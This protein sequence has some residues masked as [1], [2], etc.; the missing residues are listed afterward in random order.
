[1]VYDHLIGH[2]DIK[3]ALSILKMRG[4]IPQ[5]LLFKGKEGVGKHLFARSF[6]QSLAAS[7]DIHEYK[8]EGKAFFHPIDQIKQI[9]KESYLPPVQSAKKIFIIDQADRMLPV[10][11]NALLKTLEEPSENIV[12]ILVSHD[13]E[14]LLPTILSRSFVLSFFPL[15]HQEIVSWLLKH[16]LQNVDDANRIAFMAQGSLKRADLYFQYQKDWIHLLDALLSHPSYDKQIELIT[17]I[18]KYFSLL[19]EEEEV[20]DWHEQID[21]LFDSLIF[22]FKEDLRKNYRLYENSGFPNAHF[23]FDLIEESREDV[24]S[25]IKLRHVLERFLSFFTFPVNRQ[26]PIVLH[27]AN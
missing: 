12:F 27:P 9:I 26:D 23:I 6:A 14:R 7:I 10:S 21:L 17:K 25:H 15:S 22:Y 24:K 19:K 18:D 1:M 3:K 11:S 4:K 5:V 13:V 2:T 16:R 20:S 8:P